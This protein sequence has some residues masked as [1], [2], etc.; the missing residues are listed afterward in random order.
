MKR[1]WELVR[2]VLIAVEE[3]QSHDQQVDGTS[4]PGSDPAVVSYHIYLLKE[5]G[6]LEGVCGSY[7]N[8]PRSCYAFELTWQGHEFLDQIRSQT[9]WNKT[10]GMLREK[11]LDLSFSTIKAAAAAVATGLLSF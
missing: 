4:I 10:V 11:G 8:E 1:D 3:L 6:L 2:K 5:A 9:V 7:V